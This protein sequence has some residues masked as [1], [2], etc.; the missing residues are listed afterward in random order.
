VA[1]RRVCLE[2]KKYSANQPY[3]SE[4]CL[5]K[6]EARI[7]YLAEADEIVKQNQSTSMSLKK[8]ADR[9]FSK[10]VIKNNSKKTKE[11]L[12]HDLGVLLSSPH[13]RLR[14]HIP[15]L[16]FL[17]K[18]ALRVRGMLIEV[19]HPLKK[20]SKLRPTNRSSVSFY[21]DRPWRE[22]RYRVLKSRGRR[23]E[24]CGFEGNG[25]QVHVDHIKPRSKY[26]S[27]ELV[28]SNLQIL[29]ADCNLGKGAWDETDWRPENNA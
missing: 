26:P 13:K 14:K 15:Q 24:A 20:E 10:A 23:C 2:C 9:A 6:R 16:I 29:C 4:K 21:E 19:A 28:E 22:L 27:L 11:Q 7:R 18:E 8:E 25:K 17:V 12:A 5:S 1:I 3:C